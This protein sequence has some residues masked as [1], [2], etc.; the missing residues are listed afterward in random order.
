MTLYLE[1]H[2][3]PWDWDHVDIKL[4]TKHVMQQK[5]ANFTYRKRISMLTALKVSSLTCTCVSYKPEHN[6]NERPP[7]NGTLKVLHCKS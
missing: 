3:S 7:R 6:A 5:L 1:K 2:C 4:G